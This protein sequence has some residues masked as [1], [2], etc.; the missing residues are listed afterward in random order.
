MDDLVNLTRQ[1]VDLIWI[2]MP[3]IVARLVFVETLAGVHVLPG[4]VGQG[5]GWQHVLRFQSAQAVAVVLAAGNLVRNLLLVNAIGAVLPPGNFARGL[6]LLLDLVVLAA[7][8]WARPL[9]APVGIRS[10]RAVG[11]AAAAAAVETRDDHAGGADALAGLTG[12][13][14]GGHRDGVGGHDAVGDAQQVMLDVLLL[15]VG[16]ILVRVRRGRGRPRDVEPQ[17][18]SLHLHRPQR[19]GSLRDQCGL[20]STQA[21]G[22]AGGCAGTI[23]G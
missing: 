12:E 15:I 10:D 18:L 2:A 19:G 22:E 13:E 23:G 4:A 1:A 14:G 21:P 17:P 7:R 16:R 11:L 8:P 3:L 20:P 6:P 9:L 5:S